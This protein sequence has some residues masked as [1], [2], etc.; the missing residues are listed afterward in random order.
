MVPGEIHFA[1]GKI[2]CNAGYPATSIKV[3][4][5]GDR[6]VQVGS[7]FHFYE[8]NSALDFDRDLAW[9]KHLDI[10]AGT[11]IRFEP[12]D[13]KTVQVVDFGGRRR[14]FGFNN[15]ADCFLDGFAAPETDSETYTAMRKANMKLAAEH[16]D[17][18]K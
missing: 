11:S 9:G 10:A 15:K 17:D 4:N 13:Q 6:A 14:I 5:T 7:E 3:T 1:D 8:A 2:T 12:G 16:S 18:Q